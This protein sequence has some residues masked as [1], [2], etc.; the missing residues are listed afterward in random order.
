M[1]TH[2]PDLF[3]REIRNSWGDYNGIGIHSASDGKFVGSAHGKGQPVDEKNAQLWSAAPELLQ[4][5]IMAKTY[6]E[7]RKF[8]HGIEDPLWHVANAAIAKAKGQP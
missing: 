4:V 7:G 1:M 8:G 2:T 5:A 6:M 3:L